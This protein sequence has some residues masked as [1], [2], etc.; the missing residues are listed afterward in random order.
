MPCS[1][2]LVLKDRRASRR[3]PLRIASRRH[4]LRTASLDHP[5]GGGGM[6]SDVYQEDVLAPLRRSN[7]LATPS[8][9]WHNHPG[10]TAPQRRMKRIT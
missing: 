2:W 9:P 7:L 3:P 8:G 6:V 4:S 5:G 10:V 1:E